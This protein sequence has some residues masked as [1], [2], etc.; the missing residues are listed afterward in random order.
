VTGLTVAQKIIARAAGRDTVETDEVLWVDV[1]LAM[2]H[3]SS[4]PRR[5]WPSLEKLGVGLWD[6]DKIVI[7]SDHYVPAAD[8]AAATILQTTRDF[9]AEFGIARFHEAQGIAHTLMIEKGYALPGMLYVGADSHTCTAGAV[10]CLAVGVGSTDMLGVVTTGRTWLRVP[11][12]IRVQVDGLVPRGVT[13]KDLILTIIGDHGMDGGL[14]QVLEFVGDTIGGLSMQERSVLT[15]MCAE[16]GAKSGIVPSDDVT[17]RHFAR[18]EVDIDDGPHSDADAEYA[19]SWHYDAAA[20]EPVVARPDKHDDV[21]RVSALGEPEITRAYIGSCTGAKYEDL[22]MAAEVLEGR[23]VA[24]GVLLQVAPASRATLMRAMA[25]GTSQILM[26]AG[27][28]ILSTGCGACPGIGTGILA[29]G[30]VS[31]STTNRNSRGRMGSPDSSVYLASPY[32]VAAAAV[33]GRIVDVREILE[34]S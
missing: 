11:A 33:S 7:V 2:M 12:T 10:G 15:N 13:A 1:D 18:L 26:E 24:P 21:V 3:D 5:I 4:G 14:Y 16:I 34:R 30:E 9:A 23:S 19:D 31:V 17:R 6:A 28:H 29:A 32:T 27:A 22:V 20:L 25:D 8:G